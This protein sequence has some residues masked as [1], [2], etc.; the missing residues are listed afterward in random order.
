MAVTLHWL[1]FLNR[2]GPK[3]PNITDVMFTSC[4]SVTLTC[5]LCCNP[6][7]H[8]W[9]LDSLPSF[10]LKFLKWQLIKWWAQSMQWRGVFRGYKA[11]LMVLCSTPQ[12]LSL[13]EVEGWIISGNHRHHRC[14]Q[15]K[16]KLCLES[17]GPCDQYCGYLWKAD[18]GSAGFWVFIGQG[19]I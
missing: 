11:P 9:L 17:R 6:F 18:T 5:V 8:K 19:F 7:L 15:R 1:R 3:I 13:Q 14:T 4:F 12:Q 10:S 2:T 16:R